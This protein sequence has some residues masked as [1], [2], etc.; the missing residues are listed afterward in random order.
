MAPMVVDHAPV[1]TFET[2]SLVA[3]LKRGDAPYPQRAR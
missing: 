2:A 1:Q 3:Q